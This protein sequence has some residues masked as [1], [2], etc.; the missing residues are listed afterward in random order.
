MMNERV[1]IDPA[2]RHGTTVIRGTRVPIHRMIGNLAA[3]SLPEEVCR[4][5]EIA[6]ADRRAAL[7]YA[8]ELIELEETHP[9]PTERNRDE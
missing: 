5:Y 8:Q 1:V 6:D 4:E 3:G 9:L 7:A 2:I